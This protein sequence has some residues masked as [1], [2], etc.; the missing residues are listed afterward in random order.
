MPNMVYRS[1]VFISLTLRECF[2]HWSSSI[3]FGITVMFQSRYTNSVV[4]LTDRRARCRNSSPAELL[5]ISSET[6]SNLLILRLTKHLFHEI[7]FGYI[8]L[9]NY[10]KSL[11]SCN[12]MPSASALLES[13]KA[14]VCSSIV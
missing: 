2:K 9:L 14:F 8:L 5:Q 13:R 11:G 6:N 3:G 7:S 4:I 12:L 1:L 10:N